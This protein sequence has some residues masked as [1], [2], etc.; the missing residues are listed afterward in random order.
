VRVLIVCSSGG[1]LTQ[2]L[3]LRPWWGDHE[4]WWVTLP[5]EDARSRLRGENVVEAHYPTVRNLPNL[6]RNFVLARRVL[7]DVRPHLVFSTGAAIALPFF[8]QARSVGA[9]TAYL[10]PV[11][12]ISSPSLSGRLV[13]PF[14]DRF[15]VQWDG[16]LGA[17]PDAHNVGVVL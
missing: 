10:E 15:L 12:R 9:R 6:A 14:T 11:D 7:K 1:H 13:Y 17:Y 2:A 3:A 8:V 4:R 5:T 16:L